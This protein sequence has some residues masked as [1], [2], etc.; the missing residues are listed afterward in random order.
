MGLP[1]A[2]SASPQDKARARPGA[3]SF[4]GPRSASYFDDLRPE[5]LRAP[6]F[7][8]D[9]L[10]DEVVARFAA[11]R[12]FAEDAFVARFA[13]DLLAFDPRAGERDAE[14]FA[15]LL[16]AALGLRAVEALLK[17]FVDEP[18]AEDFAPELFDEE[19]FDDALLPPRAA[20]REPLALDLRD[21]DDVFAPLLRALLPA[22]FFA[23][24]EPEPPL[25]PPPSCLFTVA[26]ARRSAS[27]SGTPRLS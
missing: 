27:S 9:A 2:L 24:F 3:P 6:D 26:Q 5:L 14:L 16:R 22:L 20:D 7:D 10:R 12:P 17:R 23:P 18:L 4:A 21:A 1:Q 15:A 11:E 8:P 19:L 25:L 13:G